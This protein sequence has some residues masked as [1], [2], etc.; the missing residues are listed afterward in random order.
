MCALQGASA[1]KIGFTTAR[2]VDQ[3]QAPVSASSS[4]QGGIATLKIG[5]SVTLARF[6]WA[7]ETTTRRNAAR[8]III[9]LGTQI[10]E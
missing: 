10:A 1:G 6:M 8:S 5:P 4:L 7:R 2:D 9:A 3:G